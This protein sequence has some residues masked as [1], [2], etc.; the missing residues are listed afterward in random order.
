M[1]K[2]NSQASI[3]IHWANGNTGHCRKQCK[4]KKDNKNL[5]IPPQAYLHIMPNILH[6]NFLENHWAAPLSLER[7]EG[8]DFLVGFTS[9]V[10]KLSLSGRSSLSVML[11]ALRTYWVKFRPLLSILTFDALVHFNLYFSWTALPKQFCCTLLHG[12]YSLSEAHPFA[13]YLIYLSVL[14]F[15]LSTHVNGHT[16]KVGQHHHFVFFILKQINRSFQWRIQD[17]SDGGAN[18]RGSVPTQGCR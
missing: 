3:N 8:D 9:C 16:P 14:G 17:F 12:F 18:P 4:I 5:D 15:Y 2:K 7:S 13:V 6:L 11:Q 1:K 10:W